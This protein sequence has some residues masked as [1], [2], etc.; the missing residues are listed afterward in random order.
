MR[1]SHVDSTSAHDG[2]GDG[3]EDDV[4]LGTAGWAGIPDRPRQFLSRPRLLDL[5][6]RDD[7]CRLLLVS[8]P[9]GSGK[10]ALVVD[11][12]S[13][14]PTER[15]EWIT[16]DGDD[17]FWPGFVGCLER[18]GVPVPPT[19]ALPTD[20][21]GLDLRVRRR[22]ASALASEPSDVTVVLDGYEVASAGVGADLDYLLRHAGR[23]LRIV[24]V[25]R[26]DP[27]MPLYRYRLEEA[28]TEVRMSD[29]AL[30][31]REAGD[32]LSMM[33]VALAPE[34]VTRLNA[35]IRGWVTGL[36]F[37]GQMLADRDDPDSAVEQVA[38]DRGS[39]A[40]YLMG[41]V[42]ASHP[43]EV[44]ELLMAT[45]IPDTILPGL[46]EALGGR[47]AARTLALL[48]HV[49]V[50]IEQVPGHADHYRYHPF[51]RELL[52]AELAYGQP[53]TMRTLQRRAAE[54]FAGH[55]Q[56]VPSVRHFASLGAWSEV[57]HQ[58]VANLA[59]GQL[60][61]DQGSGALSRT[62][63]DLPPE[64]EDP[65]ATV[66]RAT[67]A[68]V[69]GDTELFSEQ[70]ARV[71]EQLDATTP[72]DAAAIALA[73]AVLL[74]IRARS[75]GD[76]AEAQVLAEAAGAALRG[77]ETR[78]RM[79]AHP[80]L[81]ALVLTARG[82]AAIRQGHL[83]EAEETFRAGSEAA[84]EANAD[85]LVVEC[86]GNLAVLACVAGDVARAEGLA[87]RA[88]RVA[89]EAGI[90]VGDRSTAAQVA[91]AWVDMERYEL[92]SAAEHVRSAEQS[93]LILGDPVPRT[94][95][96][97][98][99]GRLQMAHGDRA[100]GLAQV[101][102]AAV[103]IVE[104]DSWLVGRLRVETG[105]L[106]V[107]GTEQEEPA[108]EDLV[109]HS[110]PAVRA[111]GM[112]VDCARQLRLGATSQARETLRTALQLAA[113]ARLR[114]PF[115]EAPAQV[116]QLLVQDRLL[117]TEHAWLFE[118]TGTGMPRPRPRK[119]AAVVATPRTTPVEKLT[120]KE[121]E[122]LGHLADMLTTEEIAAV[123][124]ISVN[125]VRTH[126]RNILRKLGVSRRNAAV[127]A[128]REFELLPT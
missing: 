96:A 26:A 30:C 122:V 110:S 126:V 67:L 102:E 32:L 54:W 31:D 74:A 4:P 23:R 123:M 114:R 42:L 37:A 25:T 81:V 16:F 86:L 82:I 75:S 118:V 116:R 113:P 78:R 55:G 61:L 1:E 101:D 59:V 12:V 39:I 66:V 94:L 91:L 107:A 49:N 89:D 46:A 21:V 105:H 41:E 127:R 29:L 68:L 50:F 57:T 79:E 92:R 77:Q 45:S 5:L 56:L 7:R 62:L 19:T 95:L 44:R 27:V 73:V 18:L 112:L 2:Q 47:S 24:L 6:D 11:W 51:F 64:L 60:I 69:D 103:A 17:P 111:C 53:E 97:L 71:Q 14:R 104:P 115:H 9:A 120:E 35:R 80:E 117:A 119:V 70:L 48:V 109:R 106:E 33:G 87:S 38:G 43:P 28:V 20:A 99:K 72:D 63:K 15:I 3:P 10:T 34:S 93:V 65:A 76:A 85:S 13:D 36:R 90:P 128:A 98:V 124:Y 100:G 58:V 108:S 83:D 121:L 125:T 84:T 88:L 40:E 22:I 52:R 8:A